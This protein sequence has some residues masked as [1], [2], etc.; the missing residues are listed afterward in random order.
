[1]LARF[2]QISPALLAELSEDPDRVGELFRPELPPPRAQI[3]L[4]DEVRQQALR[5]APQALAASVAGMDP[6]VRAMLEERLKKLG[7]SLEELQSGRG[8]DAL[9]KLMTRGREILGASRARTGSPLSAKG[10]DLSVDKAWHGIH[11]LLCGQAEP[12]RSALSQAVLGGAEIGDDDSGYGP[13]RIF[14]VRQVAD[15]SRELSRA[16]LETEMKARFD[17]KAMNGAEIYPGGWETAGALDWLVEEFHHLRDF[18]ADT[19]A[20][21]FAIV[22]CI[23]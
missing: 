9:L 21:R 16:D 15:I 20:R 4:S 17:P 12:A 2:L 23:E 10:A 14:T 6:R 5:R 11:Y 13:A 1:M 8:T 18:Y 7:T 3:L 19:S 22:T